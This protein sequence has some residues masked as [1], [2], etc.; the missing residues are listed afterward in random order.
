MNRI[1]NLCI[2]LVAS[3]IFAVVSAKAQ[4]DADLTQRWFNESLY[5]PAAAGNSFTTGLF[6]HARQQ[7]AGMPSAP[8]TQAGTFDTYV[9]TINSGFGFTFSADKIG[10]TKSYN[11][12]LA[13]AYYF[14][15]GSRSSLSLGLSA[16][17]LSRN[18]NVSNSTIDDQNDPAWLLGNA[19]EMSPDFDFGAEYRGL[20]KLGATVRHIGVQASSNNL[21]KYSTNIWVYASSRFNA[22]S[23]FSVEPI[24]SLTYRDEIYR[25]EGGLLCYFFKTQ[26]RDTYNDRFW[27]GGVYRSDSNFAVMAGMNITPKI[28]LGYSFDYGAGEVMNIS[29]YGTHELFLAFQFN[30]I[31]YKDELCPA[32]RNSNAARKRR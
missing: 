16:G 19:S 1:L 26:G 27:L 10:P 9:E 2:L 13:Y 29:K 4:S 17:L 5:N 24:A 11:A 28:R 30:R 15:F 32:Y 25:M 3:Q 14:A 22:T 6:L 23:S 12:R 31:F 7:W 20:F 8:S 21:P 18:R